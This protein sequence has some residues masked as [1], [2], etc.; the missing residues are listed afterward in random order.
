M[1]WTLLWE[2]EKRKKDVAGNVDSR[3][4]NLI[5]SLIEIGGPDVA[6]IFQKSSLESSKVGDALKKWENYRQEIMNQICFYFPRD[7]ARIIF[8]LGF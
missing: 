1:L 4:L 8:D 6:T 7:L 2:K 5:Y 3:I